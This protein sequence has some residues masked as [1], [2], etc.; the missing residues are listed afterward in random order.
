VLLAEIQ[1]AKARFALYEDAKVISCY[2]AGRDGFWLDRFLQ[3]HGVESLV[4]VSRASRSIAAC[5]GRSPTASM[6]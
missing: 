2:E 4:V 6:P 3:V 5:A 1:A